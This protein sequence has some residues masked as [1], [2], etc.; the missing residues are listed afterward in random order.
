MMRLTYAD[1]EAILHVLDGL[2]AQGERDDATLVAEVSKWAQRLKPSVGFENSLLRDITTLCH[3]LISRADEDIKE[4]ARGGL[5]YALR[6]DDLI[7]DDTPVFG[8]QDDAFVVG[9]AV[10]EIRSC[11]G[12]A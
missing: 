4:L 11:L 10:H 2:K 1:R 6:A 8:L 3:Y 9:F 5:S 12:E 7:P